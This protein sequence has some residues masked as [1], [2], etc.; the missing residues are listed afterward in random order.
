MLTI[1]HI[2]PYGN[3]AIYAA[4]EV[5]YSPYAKPVAFQLPP[6]SPPDAVKMGDLT[7]SVWYVP[8]TGDSSLR[9]LRS[10]SI[11]VMNS[12]GSTVAKYDLGGWAG[13]N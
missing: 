12:H 9:E 13:P 1:K 2:T 10:G 3:E 8:E 4:I 6:D 5:S 7:G 11:Y